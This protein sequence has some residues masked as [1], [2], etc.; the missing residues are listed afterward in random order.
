[1]TPQ[2][3]LTGTESFSDAGLRNGKSKLKTVLYLEIL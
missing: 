3:G 1:M 2:V